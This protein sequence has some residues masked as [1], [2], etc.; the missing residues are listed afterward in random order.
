MR[1]K[2]QN[3]F[4]CM[5]GHDRMLHHTVKKLNIPTPKGSYSRVGC[6]VCSCE[7]Y[8]RKVILIKKDGN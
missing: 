8:I 3:I 1:V 5:C 7:K 6:A 2:G 4:P